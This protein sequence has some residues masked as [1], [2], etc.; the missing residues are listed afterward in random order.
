MCDFDFIMAE[1]LNVSPRPVSAVVLTTATGTNY[2]KPNKN[3]EE[4]QMASRLYY[5]GS[6]VGD[7]IINESVLGWT[8]DSNCTDQEIEEMFSNLRTALTAN[9]E[10]LDDRLWWQPETSEIFYEDIDPEKP[11]PFK[12][13]TAGFLAWWYEQ[14]HTA[15][16]N[17]T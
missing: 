10:E 15:L 2:N 12:N 13:D 6:E 8:N 7:I 17:L 1:G 11:L 5:R 14:I 16:Q 4:K 3:K 9:L